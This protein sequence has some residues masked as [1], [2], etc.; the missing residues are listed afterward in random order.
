MLPGTDFW[1]KY[2]VAM[3]KTRIQIAK[4]DI[5]SHFDSLQSHVLKL[6]DI[7]AILSEQRVFWR[8]AQSTTAEQFIAFLQKYSK[9]RSI[10]L[11]FPQRSEMCYVW[12]DVPLLAILLA[13]KKKL[14]LSHY[15]AMRIHG[16]T[17]Q[18]PTS[19]YI[20]EERSTPNRQQRQSISQVNIDDAFKRPARVSNNWVEYSGK[21]IFLL[22]GRDTNQLGIISQNVNDDDGREVRASVANI[23]RTLIDITVKPTYA[24]GVFEVAKAFE[25]AKGRVSVNKLVSMLQKMEYLYPYHQAIGFY[26][27]R[28]GYKESQ[29]DLVR[30]LP[31]SFDFYLVN[32]M[33]NPRYIKN[34]SLYVPDGL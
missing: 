8:L 6:K 30:R 11:A 20:T 12:G 26:L 34:W 24:G 9:L 31:I 10:D 23:E 16:L 32:E 5:V 4:A 1:E 2:G 27:E 28:A 29:L 21:K 17:E 7:R 19:V 15:T 14:H 18:L 3:N 13:L 25:L 22:N 33:V